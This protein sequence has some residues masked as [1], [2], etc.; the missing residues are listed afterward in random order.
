MRRPRV[1]V[2]G[3]INMDLV[4]YTERIPHIGETVLGDRF[5]MVPGGKG[6]NQ[7]LAAARLGA[8]V[9]MLGAVGN[10]SYGVQLLDHLKANG[11]DVK[12][13][14]KK[15]VSTGVALINVDAQGNNQIVVVPG[16]NFA[17]L[18]EDLEECRQLFNLNDVV[19][20]QLE[21]PLDTVGKAIELAGANNIVI[22]NPA[23]AREIPQEWLAKINY[24]VPNE[25]EVNLLGIDTGNQFA[26]FGKMVGNLVITEGAKG[27]SYLQDGELKGI[28]AFKVKA[29]DTTAAGDA[30]IGGFSVALAEGK[31]LAEAVKFGNA[32]A[33]LAV[34]RE[35]AQTSLPF[36]KEVEDFIGGYGA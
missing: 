2:V 23:P 7:A 19:I 20:M 3:S 15:P 35:G 22:L 36:R 26:D 18:P 12:Y 17:I 28:E 11:V 6:A 9:T 10:D 34:T 31:N 33:A 5:T 27:T 32:V 16:A 21:I 8:E 1:L 29:V 13:V 24:L 14:L 30:F 25:H 4:G